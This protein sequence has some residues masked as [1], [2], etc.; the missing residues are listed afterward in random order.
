MGR[1]RR[2]VLTTR[3]H[4]AESGMHIGV[5]PEMPGMHWPEYF[6]IDVCVDHRLSFQIP[7][8]NGRA[9]SHRMTG[10]DGLMSRVNRL[11]RQ[12]MRRVGRECRA[13]AVPCPS[14]VSVPLR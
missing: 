14:P 6:A 11:M 3:M 2:V 12:A 9:V 1:M 8:V 10:V 4:S 5:N 7:L 13:N